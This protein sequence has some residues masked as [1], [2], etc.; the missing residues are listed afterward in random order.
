MKIRQL[1][2]AFLREAA[3]HPQFANASAE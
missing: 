3:L 1:R 2:Q